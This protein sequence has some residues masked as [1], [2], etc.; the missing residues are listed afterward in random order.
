[1]EEGDVTVSNDEPV[2]KPSIMEGKPIILVV[3]SG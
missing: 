3:K 1:M 2:G